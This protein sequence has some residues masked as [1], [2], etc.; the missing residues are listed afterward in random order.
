MI[1]GGLLLPDMHTLE[2]FI[3]GPW[4]FVALSKDL[5][6]FSLI[7]CLLLLCEQISIYVDSLFVRISQTL[8]HKV[9]WNSVS[10]R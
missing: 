7:K 10:H 9:L 6:S 3:S 1:Q 5:L 4:E 8:S 2:F